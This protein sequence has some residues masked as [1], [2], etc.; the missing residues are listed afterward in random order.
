METSFTRLVRCRHPIQQAA[1]GGVATPALAGAVAHAGGLGMLCQFDREA[2]GE[3][4]A[5]AL[6]LAGDGAVGMGF[7]GQHVDAD[8]DSFELA[9]SRL[10]VV[11]VFWRSPDRDLVERARRA[12]PALVGWQVGSCDE[13]VAAVD[14]GCD[15]VIAQGVESGGHVRGT[16]PRDELLEQVLARV[17]IPVLVAGGIVTARDV[18]AALAAGA[19]AVRVGTRFVATVESSANQDYVAALLAARTGDD[20]VLTTAFA[21]GWPDAP[22]RVLASALHNAEAFNGE[23]VG[24]LDDA[25]GP[26]PVPRFAVSTPTRHVTGHVEAMA[27]Y[28][29]MGVG[30]VNEVSPAAD[31]V[32]DLISALS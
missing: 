6:A 1:M 5:T 15:F 31:V 22:H 4:I 19:A 10:R 12:G 2:T 24:E 20:T 32:S 28:A 16:T 26:V 14:A 13:A 7:F 21:K 25:G 9:A 3:R 23:V 8:L 11:E 29:G 17:A 18:A 30:D 27:L